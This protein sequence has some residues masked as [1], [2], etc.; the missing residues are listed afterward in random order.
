MFI[1]MKR[2][3]LLQSAV[4]LLSV[5]CVLSTVAVAQRVL[6][7]P[8]DN[9][10]V[11]E[12]PDSPL[13]MTINEM[14]VHPEF[15]Q[16]LSYQVRNIGTASVMGFVVDGMPG[17]TRRAVTLRAPLVQGGTVSEGIIIYPQ[18]E[19]TGEYKPK[20]DFVLFQDESTW[21]ARSTGDADFV[22]NFFDGV[23]RVITDAKRL[24]AQGD[25][26]KLMDFIKSPP[27]LPVA[28]GDMSKW[29]QGQLGLFRGY[30]VGSIAFRE[31]LK[32]RG[33]LKGI[34][35]KIADLER[36]LGGDKTT[37]EKGKRISM[38]PHYFEMPIKIESIS[39]G[40]DAVRFDENIPARPDWLK[41]LTFKIKNTSG[42]TI[43]RVA[44][45]LD[46]PETAGN[47]GMMAY[48]LTYGPPGLPNIPVIDTH[49]TPIPPDAVFEYGLDEK[50]FVRLKRFVESRQPL[51]QLSRMHINFQHVHFDDK[52]GWSGGPIFEHPQIPGRWS[53]IKP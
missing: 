19:V 44:F 43:K 25:E 27:S 7:P 39:I 34:S 33:D 32:V 17:S 11:V 31:S 23:K 37:G 13:K 51:D 35:G 41:G 16:S 49:E 20:I 21:G 3:F 9:I 52:T 8:P 28:T 22:V 53:S 4:I 6:Q 46:F 42:K 30:Q 18:K 14:R 5:L 40:S 12:Q 15:G 1:N 38:S 29:T 47:G 36:L 50:E 26:G 48:T 2:S 24:V 10:K 45:T